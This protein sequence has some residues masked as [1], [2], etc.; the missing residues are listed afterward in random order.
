M[1][2]TITKTEI[3]NRVGL[4]ATVK[5]SGHVKIENGD[6]VIEGNNKITMPTLMALINWISGNNG[7]NGSSS[8]QSDVGF[9]N[10]ASTSYQWIY[11]GTDT[12][13]QTNIAT[14]SLVAPIGSPTKC[15]DIKTA[16]WSSGTT[17]YIAWT[18]VFRPGDVS[19]TV[20]EMGLYLRMDADGLSSAA[21]QYINSGSYMAARYSVADSEFDAFIIDETKPVIVTWTLQFTSDGKLL[22][23]ATDAIQSFTGAYSNNYSINQNYHPSYGWA[24]KSCYMVI[25][26]DT[27][28]NNTVSM[29]QLVVPIGTAPGT[30]PTTQ[31]FVTSSDTGYYKVT[32]TGTWTA[33]AV[34][35]TVGEVGLYLRGVSSALGVNSGFQVSGLY[36]WLRLC[37]ADSHFASFVINESY[38]LTVAIT[39]QFTFA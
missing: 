36:L 8:Y 22:S 13:T 7:R 29:T 16:G 31:T 17:S 10:P 19:G 6:T 25:G 11:L 37:N 24:A 30:I 12:T 34:S 15:Y 27:T 9:N 26:S 38:N 3:E 18:A 28:T 23:N 5:V 32:Y 33:G 35:G 21:A 2:D 39:I 4:T 1:Q 20:G 14:T